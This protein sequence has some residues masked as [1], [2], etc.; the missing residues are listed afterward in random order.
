MMMSFAFAMSRTAYTYQGTPLL[1]VVHDAT[2]A[3][4]I[5]ACAVALWAN[6]H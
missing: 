6:A 4:A 5:A 1:T 3:V 2:A